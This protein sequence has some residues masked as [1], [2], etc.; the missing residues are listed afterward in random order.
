MNVLK[1]FLMLVAVAAFFASCSK[2]KVN[3]F[4]CVDE[5]G[6]LTDAQSAY[7]DEQ[8]KA[9]CEAYNKALEEYLDA[10]GGDSSGFEAEDCSSL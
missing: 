8:T 10:C 5:A 6:D 4:N 3:P 1:T 7:Y 2:E 9:N